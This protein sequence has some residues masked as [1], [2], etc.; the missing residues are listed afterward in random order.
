MSRI[1]QVFLELCRYLQPKKA[2]IVFLIDLNSV[3]VSDKGVVVVMIS[4][5]DLTYESMHK[6]ISPVLAVIFVLI[7]ELIEFNIK[8][9]TFH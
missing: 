1:D 8:P 5:V 2:S 4:L 6:S 9:T 7:A 3:S